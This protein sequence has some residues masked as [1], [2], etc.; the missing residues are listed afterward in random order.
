MT[1]RRQERETENSLL[2]LSGYLDFLQHN[3]D[4]SL[5]QQNGLFELPLYGME[6]LSQQW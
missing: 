1:K 4:L 6:G 5:V 2:P 3:Y